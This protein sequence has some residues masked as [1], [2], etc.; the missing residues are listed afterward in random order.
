MPSIHSMGE[1]EDNEVSATAF[2]VLTA[3]DEKDSVEQCTAWV[4]IPVH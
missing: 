1:K 4:S 2:K 3:E